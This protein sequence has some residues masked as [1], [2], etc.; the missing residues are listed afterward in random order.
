MGE[1]F[2]H[3]L[4][5][6]RWYREFGLLAAILLE[7]QGRSEEAGVE[8]GVSPVLSGKCACTSRRRDDDGLH[9]EWDFSQAYSV[10]GLGMTLPSSRSPPYPALPS[11]SSA[12][13]TFCSSPELIPSHA[14]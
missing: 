2:L 8:D 3:E 1:A 4:V 6:L 5:Y 10:T 12:P 14:P 7:A 11:Q 13:V 9:N